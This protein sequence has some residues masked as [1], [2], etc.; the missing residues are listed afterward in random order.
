[1][2]RNRR[3][4][5]VYYIL[6]LISGFLV[7][8]MVTFNGELS[9]HYGA[10]SATV[11]IHIVGVS[12]I[13]LIILFKKDNPF[14]SRQA[15]Y[16]YTGGAIGVATVVFN[17][18][19]FARISVSALLAL[20]LLG[21][22]ITGIIVDH[23]GFFD[24]PIHRFKKRKLL[25]LSIII[26]GIVSMISDFEIVAMFFAFMTGVNLVASRILNARLGEA[27]NIRISAF[28]NNLVGLIVSI[29]VWFIFGMNEPFITDFSFSPNIFIY[30]G[31]AVGVAVTWLSN[32]FVTKVSSFYVALFMFVGQV[33]CG[34]AI[35]AFISQ[36]FSTSNLIGGILVTIGLCINLLV[37]KKYSETL[38]PSVI[39]KEE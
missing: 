3:S 15:W 24:M 4:E 33:F 9:D 2:Y 13:S 20:G 34:I 36:S 17:N 39:N 5:I 37:D 23:Y 7:S 8:F 19:A 11:M 16:L 10:Y 22:T 26:L 6:S 29:P 30:L 21:Q 31:G 28:F 27:T 25:G 1:M 32:T 12:V 35:D 14:K 38:K 18:L